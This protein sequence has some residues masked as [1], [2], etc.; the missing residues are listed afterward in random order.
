MKQNFYIEKTARQEEIAAFF[1][2]KDIIFANSK[3]V[4]IGDSGIGFSD[5]YSADNKVGVEVVTCEN[6]YMNIK[7][8][9][10]SPILKNEK[11]KFNQALKKFEPEN[12]NKQDMKEYFNLLK[13]AKYYAKPKS[14]ELLLE[15]YKEIVHRNIN[16]K[17]KKLNDGKYSN[18]EHKI[19]F[20]M[21]DYKNK[22]Y[23]NIRIFT[24]ALMQIASQYDKKFD[25]VLVM[26]NKEIYKFDKIEKYS[27]PKLVQEKKKNRQIYREIEF[28]V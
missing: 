22:E 6:L 11:K 8:S 15:E 5:I 13:R 7:L 18:F 10:T 24:H 21:S 12:L 1:F 14:Q 20:V 2:L 19:L 9:Y 25:H 26:L 28:H 23:A 3:H 27:N 16:K 17:F 4:V